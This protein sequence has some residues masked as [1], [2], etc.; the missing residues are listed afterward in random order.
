M[1]IPGT[2]SLDHL[3]ENVGAVNVALTSDDLREIDTALSTI[4]VKG[5]R[6]NKEQMEQVADQ[7]NQDFGVALR[8]I[9]TFMS[10]IYRCPPL[11]Q[12]PA[13]TGQ[14]STARLD[15]HCKSVTIAYL[16]LRSVFRTAKTAFECGEVLP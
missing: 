11:R 3:G 10:S 16:W 4:T 13:V 2:R 7:T 15:F 12:T 6:M 5:G 8:R 1:P 9:A 14:R